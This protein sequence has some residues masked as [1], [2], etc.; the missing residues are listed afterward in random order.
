MYTTLR[1]RL[2]VYRPHAYYD[3]SHEHHCVNRGNLACCR[4][5]SEIDDCRRREPRTRGF[6]PGRNVR[7]STSRRFFRA[8]NTAF[9]RRL[10][11]VGI[12]DFLLLTRRGMRYLPARCAGVRT[13]SDFRVAQTPCRRHPKRTEIENATKKVIYVY[14]LRPSFAIDRRPGPVVFA[15]Y[16]H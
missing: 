13:C 10:P 15:L 9:T 7:E 14:F 12:G 2:R 8:F 4:A 5:R 11:V 1:T 16:S 6:S 3:V